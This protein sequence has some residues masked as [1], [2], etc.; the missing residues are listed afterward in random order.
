[1]N[2]LVAG[3]ARFSTNHFRGWRWSGQEGKEAPV[4]NGIL[5]E[6]GTPVTHGAPGKDP[7]AGLRNSGRGGRG[8]CTCTIVFQVR[9]FHLELGSKQHPETRL[10]ARERQRRSWCV[11][12]STNFKH[13]NNHFARRRLV[14]PCSVPSPLCTPLPTPP[15][16]SAPP[17]PRVPMT[18]PPRAAPTAPTH[19]PPPVPSVRPPPRRT[20]QAGDSSTCLDCS[21][22][23]LPRGGPAPRRGHDPPLQEARGGGGGGRGRRGSSAICPHLHHRAPRGPGRGPTPR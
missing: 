7:I 5:A 6:P 19:P 10:G 2:F 12:A 21:P 1:M 3:L 15:C 13:K 18:T 22:R 16:S 9:L 4:G 8:S 23:P 17:P 11:G 20:S 14:A